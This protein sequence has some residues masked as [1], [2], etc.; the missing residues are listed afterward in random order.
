MGR[1][2][3]VIEQLSLSRLHVLFDCFSDCKKVNMTIVELPEQFLLKYSQPTTIK[4]IKYYFLKPS[5]LCPHNV[6]IYWIKC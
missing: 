2:Q 5:K 3:K 6:L 4:P 1:V